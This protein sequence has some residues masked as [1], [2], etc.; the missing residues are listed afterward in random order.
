M[1]KNISHIQVLVT[2]L[3][4]TPPIKLK[5]GLQI[6]ERLLI[7]THLDKSNYLA[8]LKQKVVNQ[9][10]LTCVYKRAPK[11]VDF[12]RVTAVFL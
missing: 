2:C 10:D 5:L 9:Y 6:G 1:K 11:A 3:S 7:A 8:N 4:P 12:F